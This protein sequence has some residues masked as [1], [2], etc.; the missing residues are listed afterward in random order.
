MDTLTETLGEEDRLRILAGLGSGDKLYMKAETTMSK[1]VGRT[2]QIQIAEIV[3]FSD[4][5]SFLGL[6]TSVKRSR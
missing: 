2:Y 5:T 3:A 6:D 4:M 1:L